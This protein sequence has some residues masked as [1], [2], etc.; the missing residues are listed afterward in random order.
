MQSRHDLLSQHD[1]MEG[2]SKV[3]SKEVTLCNVSFRQ[4]GNIAI[5][6]FYSLIL[7]K[8]RCVTCSSRRLDFGPSY[9]GASWTSL[10]S[11]HELP[12]YNTCSRDAAVS[13]LK[14]VCLPCHVDRPGTS[15]DAPVPGHASRMMVVGVRGS[16]RSNITVLNFTDIDGVH[17]TLPPCRIVHHALNPR[18]F[19]VIVKSCFDCYMS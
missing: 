10:H 13:I 19:L 8:V 15:L 7:L 2:L 1:A 11:L 12:T 6:M 17:Q 18:T 3:S 9:Y 4:L 5:S 16:M 14:A